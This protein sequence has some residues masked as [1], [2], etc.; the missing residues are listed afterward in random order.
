MAVSFTEYYVGYKVIN[1]AYSD[2]QDPHYKYLPPY[3]LCIRSYKE[4]TIVGGVDFPIGEIIYEKVKA[5][6]RPSRDEAEL[7]FGVC[8]NLT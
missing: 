6:K 1:T 8:K 7:I 3:L 2:S 5:G 4:I